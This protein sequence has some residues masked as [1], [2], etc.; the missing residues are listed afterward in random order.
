MSFGGGS[1]GA[2]SIQ[3][4]SDVFLSAPADGQVLSYDS[5]TLKW[6]NRTVSGGATTIA[7]VSGLQAALDSRPIMVID[8]VST[9]GLA[10]GTLIAYTS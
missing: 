8:P 6:V 7:E 1:G 5:G 3:S 2:G 4:S 9:T 10:N